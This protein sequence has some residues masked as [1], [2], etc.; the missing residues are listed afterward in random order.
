MGVRRAADGLWWATRTATGP[1]T[2]HVRPGVTP[3]APVAARAWGPGA[4]SA[5]AA[6]PGLIGFTDHGTWHPTHP[7]LAECQRRRPGLRL[8]HTVS[9][10]ETL[11]P[12]IVA[13]K[14]PS[15]DAAR[16]W[17]RLQRVYAEPA[18]GPAFLT[19]P[20]DPARLAR[21]AYHD[22]HRFGIERRRAAPLLAACRIAPRLEQ[23]RA[24]G[25]AALAAGLQQ[26]PGIGAWTAASVVGAVTG[27]ADVV[28]VG[29]YGLPSMVA[30]NLAGERR[31]DDDR[32]LELLADEAPHRAR[33]VQLTLLCGEV[34]PRH[35]PRLRATAI[36]GPVPSPTRSGRRPRKGRRSP[37]QPYR[38]TWSGS[39]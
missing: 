28:V 31:A 2:V 15:I 23:L 12:T 20:P 8:G 5:L 32:M 14:V 22:L 4:E 38:P 9:V 18:P 30:W 26:L 39:R 17:R 7:W 35:G 21:L 13:Q 36:M 16:A 27:D 33:A 29:D 3:V 11:L 19:L 37:T 6:V 10:L 34:P 1:A 25:P 24:R